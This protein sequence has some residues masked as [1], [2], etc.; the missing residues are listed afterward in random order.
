M[1]KMIC[2]TRD[3]AAR[4]SESLRLSI[5]PRGKAAGT[6]SMLATKLALPE[7]YAHV[8][9]E[10]HACGRKLRFHWTL[11]ASEQKEN[12][13]SVLFSDREAGCL[14]VVEVKARGDICGPVEYSTRLTNVGPDA[15]R[16][17]PGMLFAG[18][19]VLHTEPTVWRFPKES[20]FAEGHEFLHEPY[21]FFQE[22]T[23]IHRDPL[24][25]GVT[26]DA[27]T[28][29]CQDFNSGGVI[30][31][32]YLE[33]KGNGVFVGVEWTSQHIRVT[34][35]TFAQGAKG[36]HVS[37]DY[38][39]DFTTVLPSGEAFTVAPI[40]LGLFRGDV[41]DG[42]NLFKR[43][44]F[45]A[46][47]PAILRRNE[48]EPLT[49]IDSQ[50]PEENCAELGIQSIK[51]DYGWWLG[52][53]IKQGEFWEYY[54]GSW[55][56]HGFDMPEYGRRLEDL[57]LNWTVYLLLHDSQ[58]PIE[59]D[60]D[61]LM[62]SV[63]PTAHPEWFLGNRKIGPGIPADLGNTECVAYCKRKLA[64]FFATNHIKTWRSDFE[65]ISYRSDRKN[66]HDANGNDVQYWCSRGFYEI[67]DHLIATVPGFRYE[68]CSSGGSM[69]DFATLTRATIFN[70]DDTAQYLS[71][72]TTFYDSSYCIPPAQLQSPCDPAGFC[73]GS[74]RFAAPW[75]GKPEPVEGMSPEMIEHIRHFG[76]RAMMMNAVM[77]SC[78]DGRD[79]TGHLAYGIEDLYREYLPLHNEKI[80]PLIRHGNLYH[81]LPRPDCVHWDGLQ[82]GCD[83]QPDNGVGGVTFVFKPTDTEGPTKHIPVR[84]LNP[85]LTYSVEFYEHKEQNFK[86]TG[87]ELMQNGF[88]VTIPESCGSDMIFY[89]L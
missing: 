43:W 55:R 6:A 11:D 45:L 1:K 82:Y 61:D 46:K 58:K 13:F 41:D 76:M 72:R 74:R 57:G 84:G 2:K 48:N 39:T 75:T 49:Q 70:N 89:M 80:K 37:V 35:K 79:Q 9:G 22:G 63:G 28:N 52:D 10:G 29:T 66:R 36:A 4:L 14:F 18:D 73:P 19:F 59:D 8:D 30:P 53:V 23:G 54:E 68:S 71:L 21:R 78:W 62:T 15:I 85:A 86:A 47:T 33:G 87:A 26:L 60:P 20:G 25:D 7:K 5:P 56:R 12:A 40:Y 27:E 34:G 50:I 77:L 81:V 83:G 44:F 3:T 17:F 32:I 65:P 24:P 51:W 88:D 42:S 31:L 16:I 38:G 69:K 64:A 67:V